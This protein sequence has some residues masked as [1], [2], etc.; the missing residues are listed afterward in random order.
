MLNPVWL[1]TFKTL[2]DVGHFTQTAEKLYMTQPGV[3]QHIKKLEDACN[4]SLIK[5]ENKGFEITEQGKIVY[6]YAL[7]TAKDEASLIDKLSFDNPYSGQCILSCSG[8]LALLLYPELLS[9]QQQ[10]P[11]LNIH[12][13]AAPNKK[14]LHDVLSG[15]VDLGIVTHLPNSNLYQSEIIAQEALCLLLPRQYEN[16]KITAELLFNCGLIDHPDAMHYLSLYFDL[17]GEKELANLNLDELPKSGYINQLNQILLPVAKGLGFTV[18]PESA[19][20]NFPKRESLY[21]GETAKKVKETL[22]LV[23]KR[24]RNLAHRYQTIS[25]LLRR[26]LSADK[27]CD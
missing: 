20:E 17:C 3:S 5:R 26:V 19:V 22:Y 12:L 24:N 6:E 9:L 23:Q 14:I 7:K 21:I 2:I 15:T 16:K 8:S 27:T 10:Y 25:A 18:L 4:H 13:E 1:N 11:D